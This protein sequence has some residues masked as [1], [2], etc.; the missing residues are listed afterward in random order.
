MAGKKTKALVATRGDLSPLS[1][2]W[3]DRFAD[4]A[5]DD[6]ASRVAGGGWPFIG[7]RSGV[8]R[9]QDELLES[10]F[11]AI[12]MGGIHENTYFSEAYDAENPQAPSCFAV[13]K[14]GGREDDLAPPADLEA[15]QHPTCLGCWANE[16]GTADTGKGKACKN[17]IRLA[18]LPAE[19]LSVEG[20]SE[21]EGARLRMPV[22][23]LKHWT[24]Y[25]NVVT[26]GLGRPLFSVITQVIIEPSDKNQFEIKLVP[27]AALNEGEILEVLEK[28]LSEAKDALEELPPRQRDDDDEKP[29]KPARKKAAKRKTA[30]G[31]KE[32][33]TPDLPDA[34]ERKR[35]SSGGKKPKPR[36]RKF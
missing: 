3:A 17:T 27:V 32:E 24:K 23:S 19:D 34:S 10:P 7:T 11:E 15:K 12:V 6:A 13:G 2:E 25:V 36:A 35:A 21:I 30:R 4:Y 29:K 9:Y 20:L 26:G 8:F 1:G 33:D 28:R 5:R 31:K 18:L 14:I 22:T 16:F